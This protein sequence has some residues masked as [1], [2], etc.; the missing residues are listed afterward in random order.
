MVQGESR[1]E[2]INNIFDVKTNEIQ[3]IDSQLNGK[4]E[5]VFRAVHSG[6]FTRKCFGILYVFIGWQMKC[7]DKVNKCSVGGDTHNSV[8]FPE[9]K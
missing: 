6:E 9:V 3:V 4:T 7:T 1:G 8:C 5:S 2:S